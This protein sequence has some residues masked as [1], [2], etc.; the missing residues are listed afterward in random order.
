MIKLR[1]V[2]ITTQNMQKAL[3]LYRDIF[4]LEVVWDE[5]EESPFIDRLSGLLDVKAHTVKLRDEKGAMIELLHFL[6]H[7]DENCEDNKTK[8]IN[9]IGCSHIA[10]TV[11]DIDV[12][13][14]KLIN[15]GLS[16]NNEPERHPDI[17]VPAKVAFCRDFDGTL[18]EIVEVTK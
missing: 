6:S 4:G 2:G 11:E 1:H 8:M 9:K 3:E 13:Y 10:I 16:F 18:I 7:P 15:I 12:M 5:I 17:N 14:D